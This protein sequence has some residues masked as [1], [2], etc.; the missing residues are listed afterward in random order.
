MGWYDEN[1]DIKREY[2]R[3]ASE[4]KREAGRLWHLYKKAE[5]RGNYEAAQE[6][7]DAAEEKY[8]KM[9]ENIAKSR[10]FNK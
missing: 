8:S 7:H 3:R 5:R 9:A 1:D 10:N 2:E 4:N 6:L